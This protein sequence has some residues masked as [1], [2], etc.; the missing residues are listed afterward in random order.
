MH[1]SNP[2]KSALNERVLGDVSE[3]SLKEY[4]LLP[5]GKGAVALRTSA[6]LDGS[7][8]GNRTVERVVSVMP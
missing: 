7:L 1:L 4:H 6:A 8:P 3:Q 5:V 2:K